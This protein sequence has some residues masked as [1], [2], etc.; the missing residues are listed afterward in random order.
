MAKSEMVDVSEK[1]GIRKCIQENITPGILC[2]RSLYGFRL[3]GIADSG[4]I[5]SLHVYCSKLRAKGLQLRDSIHQV[6]KTGF[7]KEKKGKLI[8]S[9]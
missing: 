8:K 4:D 7:V 1:L 9:V 2:K 3:L 5:G 6:E